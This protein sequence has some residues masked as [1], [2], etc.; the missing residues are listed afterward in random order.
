[1][2]LQAFDPGQKSRLAELIERTYEGTQ[3]CP[4]LNGVRTTDDVVAGYR[5][6]GEFRPE[7][8]LIA[9]DRERDVACLL[10]AD[11]PAFDQLELVYLGVIPQAR[12]SGLG[13]VLTRH[14]QWMARQAGRGKLV[15][16][17]DAD[18]APALRLYAQAGFQSWDRRS[19]LVALRPDSIAR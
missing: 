12:G 6:V 13:Y 8:W 10:L 4:V 1:V 11:H 5:A 2:T 16:A 9:S 17:V 18:N 19:V 3:D 7:N 15:L 14:A